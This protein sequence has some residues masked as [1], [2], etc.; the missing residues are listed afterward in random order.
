MHYGKAG[1]NFAYNLHQMPVTSIHFVFAAPRVFKVAAPS[2]LQRRGVF[3]V[4][5]ARTATM[6][7]RAFSVV[8]PVV[9][10]G[11]PQEIRLLH[12]TFTEAFFAKLKTVLF[13]RAGVGSASE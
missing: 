13:G 11:L 3:L 10:N 2:A 5:F 8:G 6:Q 4:P 1:F 9:W 7:N 12:G